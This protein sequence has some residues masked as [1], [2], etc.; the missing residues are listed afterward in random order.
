MR[1]ATAQGFNTG[2]Q[3]FTYLKD[4][5][6]VLYIARAQEGRAEDVHPSACIAAWLAGRANLLPLSA[7][8]TMSVRMTTPGSPGRVDIARHLAGCAIRPDFP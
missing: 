1:F 5:F 4:T 7:L 2:E 6:D 3:F 8:S